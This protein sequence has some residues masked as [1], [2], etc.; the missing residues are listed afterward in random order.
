MLTVMSSVAVGASLFQ[1]STDNRL[2]ALRRVLSWN[3]STNI[4]LYIDDVLL[5]II[6]FVLRLRLS[7][8]ATTGEI[9]VRL[10]N[11]L[12]QMLSYTS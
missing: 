5:K 6:N 12:R 11:T 4:R 7:F 2:H 8:F 3:L 9:L 1:K 10:R